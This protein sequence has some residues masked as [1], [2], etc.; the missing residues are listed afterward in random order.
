[1]ICNAGFENDWHI[2]IECPLAR[3]F[4][5]MMGFETIIIVDKAAEFHTI[6]EVILKVLHELT[7]DQ[8][9]IFVMLIWRIWK[10][11]NDILWENKFTSVAQ[12]ISIAKSLLNEWLAVRVLPVHVNII[13]ECSRWH[14]P[15]PSYRKL[16]VEHFLKRAC[17]WALV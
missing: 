6:Q 4:S 10:T 7:N 14:L 2:F 16:N 9:S 1:M 5:R 11:R 15:P 12:L 13:G 17:R 3:K 8:A